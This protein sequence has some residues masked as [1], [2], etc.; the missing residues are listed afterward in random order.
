M[1]EEDRLQF[2]GSEPLPLHLD[3]I[4]SP[5]T[6]G[7]VPVGGDGDQVTAHEPRRPECLSGPLG[8]APVAEAERLPLDPESTHLTRW[9]LVAVLVDGPVPL[10]GNHP[11]YAYGHHFTNRVGAVDVLPLTGTKNVDP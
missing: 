2:L 1:I 5:A 8:V 3:R 7:H 9:H 6:M 4:V 11:S 10:P